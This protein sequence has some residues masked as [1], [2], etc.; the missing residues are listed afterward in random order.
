M[1]GDSPDEG[2]VGITFFML[3]RSPYLANGQF[4]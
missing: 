2:G 4:Y 3:R 1:L